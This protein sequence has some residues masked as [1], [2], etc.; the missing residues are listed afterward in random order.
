MGRVLIRMLR[1]PSTAFGLLLLTVVVLLA[2]FAGQIAPDDPFDIV[3]RPYLPPFGTYLLGT[4]TLGRSIAVALVHGARAS[5]LIGLAATVMITVI[6]VGVGAI[7]GYMGGRTD[8]VLMRLTETF[9]TIPSFLFAIVLVAILQPSL[10]TEILVIGLVS[11]PPLARLVRAEV[12]TLRRRDFVQGC[13]ALGMRNSEIL[14]LQIL[15]NALPVIVVSA[16]TLVATAIL[17]EAGLSFLGLGDPNVMSW[18]LMIGDGRAA[19]RTAWWMSA[20]P[21]L[22]ILFTVLAINL[23]GDGL[24]DA[25]DPRREQR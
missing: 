9:Q 18:G 7:G 21:G 13:T 24:N 22:A 6:G 4:D 17:F 5:L 23:V 12:M 11:W 25:L 14:V 20:I 2:I 10:A 19:I 1:D 15:P 8:A 16:S 3:A